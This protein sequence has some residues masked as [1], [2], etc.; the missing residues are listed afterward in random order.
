MHAKLAIATALATLALVG[1]A[2]GAITSVSGQAVQIAPPASA[3]YGALAGPPA[4]CW[5]E[6]SGV[7]SSALLVNTVGNGVYTGG[8]Y[9]PVLAGG[10]F[11][12]HM[13]HFDAAQGVAVVQGSVTF[14]GTIVA[15]IYENTL[16]DISDGPLGAGGTTYATGNPL[17]SHSSALGSSSYTVAGNTL[18]F[19]LW[20]SSTPTWPN[21]M[22]QLRVLTDSVPTPGA[23]ALLGLAGLAGRRRRG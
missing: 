13:V 19:V 14:S 8:S 9:G 11:D 23:L 7:S 1:T 20:A 16:L 2:D 10:V 15:V 3:V 22:A 6:Q 4:F 12:S 17:R 18:S 21:D 5:N